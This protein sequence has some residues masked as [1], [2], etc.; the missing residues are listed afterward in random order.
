VHTLFAGHRY[1][2]WERDLAGELELLDPL[3]INVAGILLPLLQYNLTLGD[4]GFSTNCY[5]LVSED[6]RVLGDDGYLA[7][8]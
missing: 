3:P 6:H 1:F 7:F 8:L 5:A 2:V 4:V